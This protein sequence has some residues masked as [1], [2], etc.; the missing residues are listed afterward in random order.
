MASLGQSARS[1]TP[2]LHDV[3]G[4]KHDEILI[5][6]N[7]NRVAGVTVKIQFTFRAQWLDEILHDSLG[8][9]CRFS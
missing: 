6:V 8:R 9:S 2:D 7:V 5:K 1:S 3:S 4:C